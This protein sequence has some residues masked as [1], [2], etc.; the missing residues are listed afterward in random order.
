MSETVELPW[1]DEPVELAEAVELIA[2]A[3]EDDKDVVADLV[4]RVE[5]VERQLARLQDGSTVECPSCGAD[6]D[7]YKAG[8]GAALLASTDSLGP[9][10]AKALNQESHVCL[11]CREA[12]TPP[13]D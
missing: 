12:F 5:R 1:I 3:D 6:D 11:E 13:L 10:N 7:V 9:K 8:V 4:D 2:H